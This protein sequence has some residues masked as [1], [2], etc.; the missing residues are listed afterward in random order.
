[1]IQKCILCGNKKFKSVIKINSAPSSVGKLLARRTARRCKNAPLSLQTCSNCKLSQ[2]N[3]SSFIEDDYYDDYQMGASYSPQMRKYQKWLARHFISRFDLKGKTCFEI[4]C[5]D[6]MFASFLAKYGLKVVGI[7]PSVSFFN[8]AKCN[9]VKVLN[10]YFDESLPLKKNFYDAFVARQVF[11]HLKD[12][13]HILQNAKLYLKP[14]GVGL[15]EVPSFSTAV[16][17]KRYYDVFRDHVAYY[18]EYTLQYLLTLNNFQVIEIFHTADKE[19]L[20]VYFKNNECYDAE[21]RTWSLN[22]EAYK[23][24]AKDF[25]G[26]HKNKKIAVWG[27]GGKGIAFLSLCGIKEIDNILFVI[28]SDANKWDKYTPGSGLLVMPPRK[29]D[30]KKIDLIL[31]SAV[32]YQK[33]IIKDIR[34][35]YKY[36]NKIGIIMPSPHII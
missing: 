25:L 6:G 35:K 10:R 1:M 7:E 34:V 32:M 33:E 15:I 3:E 17:N 26:L 20:A 13:N 29:V 18:T 11:E 24:S 27:A 8:L 22:Y 30:F 21:L 36:K 9:K 12:P 31:I 14:G 28:D 4:G 19:Y 5:G 23:K 16:K 2:L